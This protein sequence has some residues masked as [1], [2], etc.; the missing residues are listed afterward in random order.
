MKTTDIGFE[1]FE[2]VFHAIPG[3]R[4]IENKRSE[5]QGISTECDRR[6]ALKPRKNFTVNFITKE[7]KGEKQ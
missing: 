3:T 7:K 6:M 5:V 1:K 2:E 4:F